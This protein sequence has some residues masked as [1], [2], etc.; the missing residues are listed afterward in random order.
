M[1]R[2]ETGLSHEAGVSGSQT[3]RFAF[4]VNLR[5]SFRLNTTAVQQGGVAVVRVSGVSETPGTD[6]RAHGDP[7]L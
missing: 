1:Y 7:V 6:H 5:P 4:T 3:Y 2:T